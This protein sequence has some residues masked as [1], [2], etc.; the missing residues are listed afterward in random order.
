MIKK[1]SQEFFSERQERETEFGISDNQLGL[2]T[3]EEVFLNIARQAELETAS[4]AGSLV[5]MNLPSGNIQVTFLSTISHFINKN[6]SN[7]LFKL[8]MM[9]VFIKSSH[10]PNDQYFS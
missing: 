3:L 2:T 5:T 6:H 8:M 7:L 1:I 9:M 4:A 10:A